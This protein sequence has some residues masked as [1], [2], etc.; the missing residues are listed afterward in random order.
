[1]WEELSIKVNI[2]DP[3]Y[4]YT[5]QNIVKGSHSIEVVY[6]ASFAEPETNINIQPEDHSGYGWFTQEEVQKTIAENRKGV[7]LLES[8]EI[9]GN[10]DHEILAMVKG[11]SL[12]KGKSLDFG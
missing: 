12:L 3:F 9:T 5:Y 11:F 10:V 6:F 8:I 7:T 2:G 1:M 4:E